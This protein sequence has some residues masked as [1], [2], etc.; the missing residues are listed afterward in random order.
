MSAQEN[1]LD[2]IGGSEH[3][4]RIPQGSLP[5]LA[6]EIRQRILLTLSGKGGHLASS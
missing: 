6:Q 2:T 1:L 3:L 4:K 5:Q